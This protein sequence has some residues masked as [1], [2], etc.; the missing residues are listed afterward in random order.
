MRL[1][2]GKS[3]AEVVSDGPGLV[4]VVFPHALSKLPWPQVWSVVFFLMLLLLGIDS[5]VRNM[6][7][8]EGHISN[9][10][11]SKGLSRYTV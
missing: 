7:G 9:I 8:R 5:Q 1:F 4:F 6:Y 2:A 3:V 10:S 11:R